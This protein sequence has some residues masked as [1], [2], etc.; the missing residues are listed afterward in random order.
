MKLI[1]A[2]YNHNTQILQRPIPTNTIYGI[3]YNDNK[4][5]TYYYVDRGGYTAIKK[6]LERVPVY[7]LTGTK[8][9]LANN[10]GIPFYRKQLAKNNPIV[11]FIKTFLQRNNIE[12]TA[13]AEEHYSMMYYD[14]MEK[15]PSIGWVTPNNKHN[16][17]R[18]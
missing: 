13:R 9:H 3:H 11:K 6:G 17:I 5:V 12:L 15:M 7:I 18:G 2:N 10:T 14:I 16:F 1:N 4:T 8:K